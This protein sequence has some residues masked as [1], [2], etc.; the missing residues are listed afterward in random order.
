MILADSTSQNKMFIRFSNQEDINTS[1]SNA[2][3][4]INI[5]INY[6]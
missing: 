4:R 6:F 3:A 2:K 1:T 5:N